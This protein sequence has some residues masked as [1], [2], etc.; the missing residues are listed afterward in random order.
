MKMNPQLPGRKNSVAL[1]LL[2]AVAFLSIGASAVHASTTSGT[3]SAT[4]KYA[5]SNVGG[6]VNFAV[7]STTGTSDQVTVTDSALTGYAWSENDGWIN[8]APA[9]G[10]V[11]NDGEGNLSGYAWDTGAGW[12]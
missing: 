1:S 3:I 12:G 10:G 11:K 6:W 2:F 5:W 7:S 9:Q 8:L 4:D